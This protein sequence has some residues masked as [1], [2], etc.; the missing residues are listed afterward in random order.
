MEKLRYGNEKLLLIQSSSPLNVILPR[1]AKLM[2]VITVCE[3]KEPERWLSSPRVISCAWLI[4]AIHS[5]FDG[6]RAV[7]REIASGP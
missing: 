5:L 6:V 4:M 7:R 2:R 3:T 1:G